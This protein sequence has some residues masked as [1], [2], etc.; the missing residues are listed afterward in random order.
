MGNEWHCNHCV[1]SYGSKQ[2]IT[3][4]FAKKSQRLVEKFKMQRLQFNN[5]L[6]A[7][8]TV[9]Q[10]LAREQIQSGNCSCTCGCT[11]SVGCCC[12]CCRSFFFLLF[13]L[14]FFVCL[15]F[16]VFVFFLVVFSCCCRCRCCCCRSCFFGCC[17]LL[18]AVLVVVGGW[19]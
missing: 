7:C 12:C 17:W 1:I 13:F 16:S 8:E 15:F 10:K 4:M 6:Q 2:D 3:S 9:I 19:W 18:F 11:Y 5:G 14:F